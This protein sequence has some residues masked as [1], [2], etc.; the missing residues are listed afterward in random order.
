[1][2][3]AALALGHT[4]APRAFAV[5]TNAVNQRSWN[6]IIREG[7]LRGLIALKDRR[8]G[9]VAIRYAAPRNPAGVRRLAFQLLGEVGKG[10]DRA[11][12][13]LSEAL[14]ETPTIA[15]D[16]IQPLGRLGDPRAIRALEEF[17]MR[18]DAWP[19]ARQLAN[20]VINR[21]RDAARQTEHR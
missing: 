5:L 18:D 16:A 17:V 7:A 12:S 8:S 15:I 1:V 20:T 19:S 3:E 21:L 10:N 14:T 9:D 2:A 13:A 6:D 4:G 11:L